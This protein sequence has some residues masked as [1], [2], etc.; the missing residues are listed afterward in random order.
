MQTT[1]LTYQTI[2]SGPYKVEYKAEIAGE[3]YYNGDMRLAFPEVSSGLFD[4]FGIGN[5]V[6]ASLKITLVP[7][8]VIP[9][10]S[11]IDLYYRVTNGVNDSSW[12]SKGVYFIDTRKADKNGVMTFEAYDSM[13]KA[14]YVFMESGSWVSTTA[15][16]V[17]NMVASDIGVS[18]EAGTTSLL[19]TDSMQV[20][21]VPI[22]GE[23]GTTGREMLCGVAAMYG[24]NF[25]IDETGALK[26]VQ[27]VTPANTATV[28]KLAE[29]IDIADAFDA[30]DRV[31]IKVD[32]KSYFR[33]PEV[34]DATWEAMTGRILEA[35]CP[36]ASQVV[37]DHV[38]TVVEDFVY[39]PYEA[40]G[41]TIDPAYQLG[42]GVTI[43]GTTSLIYKQTLK[44]DPRCAADLIAPF[45]KEVNHEY[46]YRPAAQ[47]ALS[48][49]EAAIGTRLSVAEDAITAE[50]ARAISSE[51]EVRSVITQTAT[52]IRAEL[53]DHITGQR[54]F[55][56][57]GADGL[58]LGEEGSLAKQVLTNTSVVMTAPDGGEKYSVKA[59]PIDGEY[60]MFVVNGHI[61]NYLELG[62]HWMLVASASDNDNRLTIRWKG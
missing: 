13:L 17:V 6:A 53:I 56:Q 32:E 52:D 25:I 4:K 18:V 21:I 24:G 1:D 22:I 3:T 28:G 60:K 8:G 47:R 44:L 26:L 31:I 34:S 15:L 42:D 54:R 59:D 51:N 29:N 48:E 57:Y 50:V 27:L 30:I 35:K 62:D 23:D 19:T 46:P 11:E 55:I 16:A 7:K 33:S 10:M 49:A 36:W 40:I 20:P 39:Q 5:A 41:A 14:E 45:D 12:K 43:N 58:T 38:L 2:I 9:A 61:V 37:A